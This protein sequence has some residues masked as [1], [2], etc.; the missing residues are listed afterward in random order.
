MSWRLP[1]MTEQVRLGGPPLPHVAR[2]QYWRV[3]AQLLWRMRFDLLVML[4]LVAVSLVLKPLKEQIDL[5]ADL[6]LLPFLGIA[7]SVF[8]GFRCNHAITRWWEARSLWGA[9][10]NQS[11]HWR[12]T[13]QGVLSPKACDAGEH[14]QL[15]RL[16]VLL[17]WVLN[18]ELR[19]VAQASHLERVD[20]LLKVSGFPVSRAQASGVE[21]RPTLQ[22]LSLHRAKALQQLHAARGIN[23]PGRDALLRSAEAFMGAVG[24]LQKIRNTPI[25]PAFDLFVRLMAWL[26]GLTLFW[27]F[28]D[29]GEPLVGVVLFV[30][31]LVAERIAA[32][33]EGPFDRDG[34]SFSLP[35]NQFCLLISDDLLPAGQSPF[36]DLPRCNDPSIWT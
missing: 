33:V 27:E 7:V 34:C 8:L 13:L 9:V 20:Q 16:Q 22:Q 4:G 1:P 24:G 26:F 35:L 14:L 11:R 12:D 5:I 15:L 2:R 23:N 28:Q 31:F 3:L 21:P 25:P 30:A 6:G 19:T 29:S 10:I 18:F 36:A 17:V 32:Y